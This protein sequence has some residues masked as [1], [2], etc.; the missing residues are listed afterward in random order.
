MEAGWSLF[1]SI[2]EGVVGCLRQARRQPELR[3]S[4]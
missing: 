1:M 3:P 4:S 2:A